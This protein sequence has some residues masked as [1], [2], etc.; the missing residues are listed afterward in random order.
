MPDQHPLR[1]SALRA[2]VAAS[3]LMGFAVTGTLVGW[4]IDG[5]AG[6]A[7]A[8]LVVGSVLGVGLGIYNLV[9]QGG[10]A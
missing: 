2:F 7:P 8:F 9:R 5:R 6:S 1:R 10:R 4:W 3:S